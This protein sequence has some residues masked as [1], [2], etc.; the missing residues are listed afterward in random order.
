M[1]WLLRYDIHI[2]CCCTSEQDE[3]NSTIRIYRTEVNK[4]LLI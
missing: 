2:A 4:E 1:A 3:T